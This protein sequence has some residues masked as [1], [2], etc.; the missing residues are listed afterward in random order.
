MEERAFHPLDYVS[1]LRRRK[2]WFITPLALCLL[3]GTL[4]ALFLPR[5]YFTQAEIGVAAPTLSTELLK[6]VQSM[7]KEERQRAISQQLLSRTVLE[8]VV[9]E[10]KINP[11][12]PV[13]QVAAWLRSRVDIAVD[14]PLGLGENKNGLDSFRLGYRDST[15]EQ[16]MRIANRLAVVFVEENSKTR[17]ERAENTS[18]VLGRQLQESQDRL[19]LLEEQLAVKKENY[20]GR[21]PGQIDAN[22]QMVNGL[23]QQLESLSTQLRGEQDRLSNVESQIQMMQQ[24][25]AG[26]PLATTANSVA[27]AQARITQLQQQLTQARSMYKD[28]HPE[29]P[30]LQGQIAQAKADLASLK[31]DSPSHRNDVLQS[32]PLYRQKIN[33]RDQIRTRI[34]TLQMAESQTRA[35]I[36]QFQKA[37][38]DG[39]RVEQ[40]L[41]PLTRDVRLEQFRYADLKKKH[42][43]ALDAERVSRTQGGERFSVLYGAG[44]PRSPETPNIPKV[45]MMALALGLALGAGLVVGREF[46][47]R[48]VH[49]VR[50]LQS[51]FEVPVLG[52][53]P[54]IHGAA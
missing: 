48:S 7:D 12:A 6:G 44:L 50:A 5:T 35:Q 53:I 21:L 20:M 19:A 49:D 39:P 16:T 54:R 8:R 26:M 36:G 9:R 2:W 42:G 30:L 32:D 22:I 37:V 47:D 33:E 14:K 15:P 17:T 46:L 24:G 13:D 31:D 27:A 51:E 3:V 40:D 25:S 1:V 34:K 52:E 10:E 41:E 23:R 4:L 43:D 29:I 38:A 18:E 28:T 11:E 45:L